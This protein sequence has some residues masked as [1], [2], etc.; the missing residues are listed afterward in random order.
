MTPISAS[1]KGPQ[2]PEA[3]DWLGPGPRCL[4]GC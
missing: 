2:A 1:P 3:P 4:Y